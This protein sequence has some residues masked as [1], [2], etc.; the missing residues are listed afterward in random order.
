MLMALRTRLAGEWSE[1][2]KESVFPLDREPKEFTETASDISEHEVLAAEV[3][4][5]EGLLYEVDA[6]LLRWRDGTYGI[7]ESTGEQIPADRLRALPWTR[8]TREAA[9][10]RGKASNAPQ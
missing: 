8:L 10:Q 3:A 1:H 2:M 5:E 4:L 7:C 6:A 9:E